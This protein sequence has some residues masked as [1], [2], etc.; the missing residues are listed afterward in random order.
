MDLNDDERLIHVLWNHHWSRDANEEFHDVVSFDITY[1]VNRYKMSF[2]V[3]LRWQSKRGE[4]DF[5][6]KLKSFWKLF[7]R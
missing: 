7:A 6:L 1:L 5:L 2:A 4:L 3:I